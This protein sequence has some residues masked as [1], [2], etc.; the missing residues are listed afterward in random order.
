MIWDQVHQLPTILRGLTLNGLMLALPRRR[1]FHKSPLRVSFLMSKAKTTTNSGW[2][3]VCHLHQNGKKLWMWSSEQP[4]STKPCTLVTLTWLQH[5][6]QPSWKMVTSKGQHLVSIRGV[7]S[8]LIKKHL[9]YLEQEDWSLVPQ[10]GYQTHW[11]CHRRPL[12]CAHEQPLSVASLPE[13]LLL[14]DPSS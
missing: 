9:Y 8:E 11:A 1:N 6:M 14:V 4:K 7:N 10:Q 5:M 2:C 13:A 3:L 12:P